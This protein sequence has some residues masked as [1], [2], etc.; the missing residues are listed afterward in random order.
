MINKNRRLTQNISEV[1]VLCTAISFVTKDFYF[2]R[3]L[4]L[5]YC[6]DEKITVTPRYYVFN[7]RNGIAL[8]KHYAIIG[9]AYVQQDYPLYYDA[10]NECGL[11]ISGLN[12]PDNAVYEKCDKR[13]CNIAPFEFIPWILSQCRNVD[14]AVELIHKTTIADIDF[15]ESLKNTP[16]HWFVSDRN[17]W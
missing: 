7:F 3:N 11:G 15:N 10:V 8:K 9:M 12:F 2:G 5:E 6:Y 13:M 1:I 16:L 17:K 4:D 14:E